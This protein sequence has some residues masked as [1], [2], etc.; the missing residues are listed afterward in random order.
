ML[1]TH[2]I[3]GSK[4]KAEIEVIAMRSYQIARPDASWT[5]T[6]VIV[7]GVL[8]EGVASTMDLDNPADEHRFEV[9]DDGCRILKRQR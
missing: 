1:A 3:G 5:D 9:R 8:A 7:L 6:G 2:G 4:E